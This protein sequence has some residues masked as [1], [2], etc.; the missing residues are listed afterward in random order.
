MINKD[1]LETELNISLKDF[2]VTTK[3]FITDFLNKVEN[4][5]EITK[6]TYYFNNSFTTFKKEFIK[7]ENIKNNEIE[8]LKTIVSNDLLNYNLAKFYYD[9]ERNSYIFIP[10]LVHNQNKEF[11]YLEYIFN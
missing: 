3:E 5:K 7:D 11:I 2:K 6:I 10:L 1:L 9:S 8:S 4:Q